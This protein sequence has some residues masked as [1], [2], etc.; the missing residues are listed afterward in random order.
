MD[1]WDAFDARVE[2]NGRTHRERALINTQRYMRYKTPR[3]LASHEVLINGVPQRVTIHN[4]EEWDEKKIIA[5]PGEELPHGGI[6]DFADNK[7]LI[8]KLEPD[9][10][11]CRSGLMTQCNYCLKWRD[12]D[13]SIV[14]KWCVIKDSTK[15]LL[16]VQDEDLMSIGSTRFEMR[17]GKDSDTEKLHRDMRFLVYDPQAKD[18][19]AYRISKPNTIFNLYNEKGI[20]SFILREDQVTKNDNKELM[21]A[22]YYNWDS[23]K[24]QDDTDESVAGGKWI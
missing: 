7:W 24:T 16:G 2:A 13:G 19:L 15:Y 6:V 14:E 17:I 5:L 10:E 1:V 9:G 4:L 20:Y 11:V 22:D 23:K 3:S 21:I 18:V 12:S 8:E